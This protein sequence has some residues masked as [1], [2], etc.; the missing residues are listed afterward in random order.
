MLIALNEAL[1]VSFFT[2][3]LQ[4]HIDSKQWENQATNFPRLVNFFKGGCEW[5]RKGTS[6]IISKSSICCHQ[7][8][9]AI[10]QNENFFTGK[11][12]IPIYLSREIV[13]RKLL[14]CAFTTKIDNNSTISLIGS[15]KKKKNCQ[16]VQLTWI[17]VKT[18]LIPT[19]FFVG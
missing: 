6:S 18:K 5:K 3:W 8:Q 12:R 15:C 7:Q 19:F 11:A 2:T 1:I 14:Y 9:I 16:S 10:W 13:P 17:S 4:S